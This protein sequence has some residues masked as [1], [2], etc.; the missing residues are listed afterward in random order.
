MP[1][2][3]VRLQTEGAQCPAGDYFANRD[4]PAAGGQKRCVKIWDY[5]QRRTLPAVE[6]PVPA[7][8][9]LEY[10][11]EYD[12]AGS[13]TDTVRIIRT[14]NPRTGEPRRNGP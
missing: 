8:A 9:S 14:R 5:L 13:V 1:E 7:G 10:S 11:Y 3:V 6:S 12:A 4:I 2:N